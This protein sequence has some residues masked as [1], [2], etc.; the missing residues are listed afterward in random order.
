M[1]SAGFFNVQCGS[2]KKYLA[3]SANIYYT[4]H[5]LEP[6]ITK[7]R[8]LLEV[9]NP[10]TAR[11][12]KDQDDMPLENAKKHRVS[13]CN[14]E[15]VTDRSDYVHRNRRAHFTNDRNYLVITSED[16]KL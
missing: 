13:C 14:R 3:F 15:V 8:L 12:E 9:N 1:V 16:K 4:E 6:S 7:G 10:A 5:I 2:E 11:M